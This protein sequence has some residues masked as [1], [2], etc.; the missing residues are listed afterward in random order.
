M[1]NGGQGSPARNRPFMVAKQKNS[2]L[3]GPLLFGNVT[4]TR[5]NEKCKDANCNVMANHNGYCFRHYY[6]HESLRVEEENQ[7]QQFLK[8]Q[9]PEPS[10]EDGEE[11]RVVRIAR[12]LLST[13]KTYVKSLKS[14]CR[15][16]K[17][18]LEVLNNLGAGYLTEEEITAIFQNVEHIYELHHKLY[19]ELREAMWEKRLLKDVGKLM[20]KYTPFFRLYIT[21]V[22][23][24]EKGLE[25]L[26]TT[27]EKN[28]KFEFFLAVSE[29]V[30]E[31]SL[32]SLMI[33]PVQRIPR[34][35]L[36]LQTLI[37]DV[38][39]EKEANPNN[40]DYDVDSLIRAQAQVKKVADD[41]N[42]SF[43]RREQREKVAQI[44]SRITK[45]GSGLL[46]RDEL[47]ASYRYY[48][49]EGPL[50]KRYSKD[51][52]RLSKYEKYYF[53]LFNDILM[54]CS[55]P[56]N[57]EKG[58]LK[59]HNVLRLSSMT[60]HS[61]GEP[62]NK[63]RWAWEMHSDTKSFT[64]AAETQEEMAKWLELLRHYI[65]Q[66]KRNLGSLDLGMR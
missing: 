65:T 11:D 10:E 61:D 40:S 34:Y 62:D 15:G 2:E 58:K 39:R 26:Q 29:K 45:D 12:E 28:N 42:T 52:K 55:M 36:L 56:S 18:R 57:V 20:L 25:L 7:R 60:V 38:E 24:Y 50:Y 21:Y 19:K 51:S 17:R 9:R 59:V 32:E 53:Y 27:R 43:R 49:F 1:V 3:S 37:K 66:T 48:V 5:G 54:Y 14:I 22:N 47:V 46:A 31:S 6:L 23:D 16:F 44:A 35:L 63:R 33:T 30:E 4:L 64:V 13:E 8:A 41:I